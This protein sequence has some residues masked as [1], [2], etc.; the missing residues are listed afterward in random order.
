VLPNGPI[1]NKAQF[2]KYYKQ[3][4]FGNA[5]LTWDNY[6]EYKSAKY[7]GKVHFRN[8]KRGGDTYYNIGRLESVGVANRLRRAG[9]LD[10]FYISAMAPHERNLLQG[11]VQQTPVGLGLFYSSAVGLPMRDALALDGRQVYGIEAVML[12]RRSL[13]PKSYDWLQELLSKYPG[14]VVEFSTF[15]IKW[16]TLPGFN[17]VFWEV[18]NY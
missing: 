3:G 16:G 15:S 11:E 1:N 14:H 9:R 5:S 10:E 18:R 6:E 17:T 8:R 7:F 2:V 12:L 13:C 4:L